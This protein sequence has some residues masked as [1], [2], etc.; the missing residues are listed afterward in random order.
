MDKF[1][2]VGKA[3]QKAG[4]SVI[5][6]LVAHEDLSIFKREQLFNKRMKAAKRPQKRISSLTGWV[7]F[8]I[9]LLLQQPHQLPF[10]FKPPIPGKHNG[11][12]GN[13]PTE[14][15]TWR[16]TTSFFQLCL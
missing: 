15:N 3:E 14:R 9:Q 10:S 16:T 4:I 12:G 2:G 5:S 13:L 11:E 7:P 1:G 6:N 8:P